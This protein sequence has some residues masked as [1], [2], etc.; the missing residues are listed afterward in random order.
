M[1]LELWNT[2]ATIGT[3]V[4]ITATAIAALVQLRHAR[5]AY[6]ITGLAELQKTQLSPEFA[7]AVRFIVTDLAD[8]LKD[9]EFRYQLFKRDAR[10]SENQALISDMNLVGNYYENLGTLAMTG[11]I[12]R[13]AALMLWD[14]VALAAWAFLT[15]ALAILRRRDR[16]IWL[17][18]EYFVVLAQDWR[19]SHP[20]GVYPK[21][22]RHIV[23]DD[24]LLDA[25]KRYSETR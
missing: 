17:H 12:D 16:Q 15:P 21:N 1:T 6:Q 18:F 24:P 22:L 13:T 14:G 2:L 7:A 3:F 5:A 4:V 19:A 20:D 8:K 25:D 10:T 9:P 11:L 23:V